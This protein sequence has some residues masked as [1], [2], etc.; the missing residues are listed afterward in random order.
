MVLRIFDK[1]L[2]PIGKI[3]V[4]GPTE[5][6]FYKIARKIANVGIKGNL[7]GGDEHVR[8]IFDIKNHLIKSNW[9]LEE[10]I[11]LMGLFHVMVFKKK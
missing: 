5:N 6:F 2:S 7:K 10:D 11:D 8:D 4:S 1:I 3:I 9:E